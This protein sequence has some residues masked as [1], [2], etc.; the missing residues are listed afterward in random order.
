MFPI[1]RD[2]AGK[3]VERL[4]IERLGCTRN[5]ARALCAQGAVRLDGRR[6]VKGSRAVLG[7]E[8]E[9]DESAESGIAP[10][11]GLALDVRLERADL[12]VVEKPAGMPTVPLDPGEGGTLV[13]ALIARY[14]EML[15][16]GRSSREPGVLHRLDT[17]T[18]G[19][20]LAARDAATFA[21][22][23]AGLRAGALEKRYLAIC[24]ATGLDPEGMIDLP[25]QPDPNRYGRVAVAPIG[26]RYSRPSCTRFR[27]LERGARFALLELSVSRA[28]RHQ[29]RAHLA[30][31]G[32]PIAGDGLYGGP[33]VGEL[34]A[35]HALHASLVAFAGDKTPTFSVASDPPSLFLELVRRTPG[36]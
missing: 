14:P 19:L 6:A 1:G 7:A 28:F 29:I 35:R 12:V 2:C 10:E 27:V 34:G 9:V 16:F 8:L 22:L 32:H 17:Q 23:L 24:D 36:I 13:G 18:S 31:M 11:P 15:G 3:R 30:A 26:A 33:V 20:V 25:L 5:Q 21:R 4:L